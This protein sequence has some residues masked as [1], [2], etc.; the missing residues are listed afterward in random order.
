MKS[1]V[2][3]NGKDLRGQISDVRIQ[4]TPLKSDICILTSDVSAVACA[5]LD[6]SRSTYPER[7]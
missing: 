4:W 2:R 1:Q 7:A 6:H 5:A 3:V